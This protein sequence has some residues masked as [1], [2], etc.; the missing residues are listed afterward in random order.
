MKNLRDQWIK[1]HIFTGMNTCFIENMQTIATTTSI[2]RHTSLKCN[3]SPLENDTLKTIRLPFGIRKLFRGDVCYTSMG[4]IL[5]MHSSNNKKSLACKSCDFPVPGSPSNNKCGLK[6]P[7]DVGSWY[8]TLRP[9]VFHDRF[10][11]RGRL[12]TRLPKTAQC[13]PLNH[14]YERKSKNFYT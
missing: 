10:L 11:F 1:K 7:A 3:S 13:L 4:S 5:T 12:F 6:G 2:K 14:A 8:D 9:K